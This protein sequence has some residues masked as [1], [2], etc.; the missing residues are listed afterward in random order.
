[1]EESMER[2]IDWK[3][4]VIRHFNSIAAETARLKKERRA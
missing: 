1:M 2:L 3:C 4:P